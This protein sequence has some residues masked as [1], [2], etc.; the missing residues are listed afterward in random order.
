[1]SG[2]QPYLSSRRLSLG[3]NITNR[4]LEAALSNLN[5]PWK[6]RFLAAFARPTLTSRCTSLEV[7]PLEMICFMFY[8]VVPR[9][10]LQ[11]SL[12]WSCWAR[13]F[14]NSSHVHRQNSA[15]AAQTQHDLAGPI[16]FP[17]CVG[18]I[19]M[20]PKCFLHV[21]VQN[22]TQTPSSTL[23]GLGCHRSDALLDLGNVLST[24][25]SRRYRKHGS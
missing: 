9:K 1:M 21:L 6:P 8:P 5:L 15:T 25:A 16:C 23:A 18:G 3:R 12:G 20:G 2:L 4:M 7:H 10:H 14:R 17:P 11:T 19:Q 13:P 24:T 22:M